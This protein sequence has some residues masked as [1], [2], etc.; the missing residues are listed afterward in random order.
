MNEY[1]ESFEYQLMKRLVMEYAE[2]CLKEA[3][4]LTPLIPS[5][6]ANVTSDLEYYARDAVRER[7]RE[8][9]TAL[10]LF[11]KLGRMASKAA[12]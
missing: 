4:D 8:N 12:V 3:S 1:F 6:A 11:Y 9:N 5:E 10:D 2:K 7:L